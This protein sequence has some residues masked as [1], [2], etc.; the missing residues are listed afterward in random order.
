MLVRPDERVP[1]ARLLTFLEYGERLAHDCARAQAALAPEQGMQRF[2]ASQARQESAHAWVFQ[3]AVAW[4]APKHLG[5]SPFLP[6]LEQYRA[7]LED[8]LQRGDLA[9]TLMAEQLILEG[10]GEAIL[11]RIEEGLAK[12]NARFGQL[13]R[14]LLHQEEAHYD[15]GRRMLD[16]AFAAGTTSPDHLCA[17]AQEYLALTDRMVS[18]L[19]DLFESIEEDPQLYMARARSYLP[20]WLTA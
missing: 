19:G 7:L 2:L 12:R 1:I 17:R 5:D 15:F 18:T 4:L 16:R 6:A 20:G 10:L 8:A 9:E 11:A 14:I 13:R 3:G